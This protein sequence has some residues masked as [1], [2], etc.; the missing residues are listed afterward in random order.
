M[1]KRNIA[2]DDIRDCEETVEVN[3]KAVECLIETG[4]LD[5]LGYAPERVSK[6]K[7]REAVEK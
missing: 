3:R 4:A 7:L 6:R 1:S 5:S 2:L